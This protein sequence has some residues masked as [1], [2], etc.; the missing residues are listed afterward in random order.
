[1][2]LLIKHIKNYKKLSFIVCLSVMV[3]VIS[4]LWQPNLLQ[5]VST[6]ILLDDMQEIRKLGIILIVV[7]IAGLVAGVINTIIS[8]KIA[9]NIGADMREE[10]F[11]KVQTFSLGN[12]E[13]ISS[14]N[15]VVRLTNDITQ[16]Q[17]VVM[18]SLQFLLRIP[19]L[20]IG[21]FILAM[22][23]IPELWW[24]IVVLIVLILL[25]T[26][27]A[28]S[29]M[30][31][32][33][34]LMQTLVDKINTLAKENLMGIRVVKSFV[35]EDNERLK[36]A[37][38]SNE[39]A[40]VNTKLGTI[41]SILI[42]SFF[43]IS[44]IMVILAIYFVGTMVTS[45]PE[46]IASVASFA[47][48]LFQIMMAIIMGGML[49]MFASRAGVSLKRLQEIINIEPDITYPKGEA[50]RLEGTIQ[51]RNVSFH[52]PGDDKMMLKDISF[53]VNQGEV[54]GIVGA[55]GSGKSTMVQLIPRLYDVSEGSIYIGGKPI[56]ELSEKSLS[57]NI[58]LV[59]QKAILFSGKIADNLKHGKK[60]ATLK[61]MEYASSIAQAKEFIDLLDER[62]EAN[63][64]ER[65]NNFSG[66][67]KQRLSISRGVIGKPNILI[68]DDS[69]SALDARSEKLVKEAL[70]QEL[71]GTTTIIIA[72]KISSVI[73][74]D[75]ILVLDEGRLV[76]KGN[77]EELVKNNEV[78]QK[79]YL[80]QKA[81]EV[82]IHE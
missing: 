56:K 48:Y 3:M 45:Q 22:F 69:T 14:G 53:M 27:G 23:T 15:I 20:F 76:G 32:N 82:S 6:A 38:T 8:A 39:L 40:K 41:F 12:I 59:L 31:K 71:A 66:G 46:M 37:K 10:A 36:F 21:S 1:M 42:P 13:T 74:A 67:Q 62:Y 24:I 57:N 18:M 60:D 73:H 50:Q 47:M 80:S 75:S 51:F 16:I 29:K 9:Q 61:D 49:M 72:Q 77:H 55:T 28:F 63:V 4:A 25:F 17:N 11:R 26:M 68:L 78:Y 43:L 30:G 5:K 70:Q 34:E 81:K 79:I 64:E 54:I 35:Q 52:Y 65:G 7:A 44:D 58:S 2:N 19:F 33:F